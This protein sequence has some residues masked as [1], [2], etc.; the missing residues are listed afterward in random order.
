MIAKHKIILLLLP[1]LTT[2]CSSNSY[3]H[4]SS[5][6]GFKEAGQASFYAE[7]YQSRQT[8]S[9]ERFNQRAKTAA[10]KSLPF[11][12]RV[13]VTNAGNGKTVTV[14]INDRGP[15]VAG[16]IIDLS[17]SAFEDIADTRL[18]VIDVEVEV[19]N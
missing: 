16:R 17:R 1:V 15:F 11:G 10:H 5:W 9:G 13:K 18:G 12:S 8:A 6:S 2:V 14:R 19:I 7:K 4:S 3:Q